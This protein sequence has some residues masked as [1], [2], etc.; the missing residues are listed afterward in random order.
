M[1]ILNFTFGG[2]IV[3]YRKFKRDTGPFRPFLIGN[4]TDLKSDVLDYLET[5]TIKSILYDRFRE[6]KHNT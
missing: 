6:Q 4:Y 3:G 5:F 1:I 2:M